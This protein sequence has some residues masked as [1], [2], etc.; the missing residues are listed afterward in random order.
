MKGVVREGGGRDGGHF[1]SLPLP[2]RA[3][4]RLG[5]V[6]QWRTPATGWITS[7]TGGAQEGKPSSEALGS[8][9]TLLSHR[10]SH[11]KSS[12]EREKHLLLLKTPT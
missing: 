5:G 9:L 4:W 3:A 1:S 8:P 11:N 7:S 10:G 12:E 2:W 6:A